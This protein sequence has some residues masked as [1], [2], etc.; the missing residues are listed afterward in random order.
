MPTFDITEKRPRINIFKISGAYYFKHFFDDPELFR[1][2]EPYYE[3]ASYRFKMA[4]A[5]ERNKVM[6]L[7]DRKGFDPNIIEDPAPYTV[8][9]NKY[10]KYGELLKNS[11]E[12]YPLRDKVVLVMR[13]IVWVEQALV[14]GAKMQEHQ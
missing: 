11:K 8:E 10:Q 7:L 2:L 3:T 14:M 4:T 13:D 5:G 6:K 9:I 12:S 1:E